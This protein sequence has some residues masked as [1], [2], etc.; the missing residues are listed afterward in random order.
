MMKQ[1]R[2]NKLVIWNI[3]CLFLICIIDYNIITDIYEEKCAMASCLVAILENFIIFILGVYRARSKNTNGVIRGVNIV[4]L[5]ISP[6]IVFY[7]VQYIIGDGIFAVLPKYIIGNLVLYFAI[8]VIFFLAFGKASVAISIYSIVAS[9]WALVDYY[10][11]LFRGRGFVIMDIFSVKTAA[12]V[13]SNYSFGLSVDIGTAL[14]GIITLVFYQIWFQTIEIKPVKIKTILARISGIIIIIGFLYTNMYIWESEALYMW[15]IAGEY[16][17]KG[18][19]YKLAG[20]FQYLNVDKPEGYSSTMVNSVLQKNVTQIAE[21]SFDTK[22][23]QTIP[24][25]IIVIMN[26]S[27]ADFSE[28]N[29]YTASEDVLP[30]IH[31]LNRNIKKG[32][33]YVPSFGGGTSDTEYEVLTGNTKEFMPLGSNAYE[34]YCERLQY[35]LA[36]TLKEQNYT[37]I[38]VH[39]YYAS[40]WNRPQVYANMQFDEFITLENWEEEITNIREYASD[41][42]AYNKIE[43]IFENKYNENLFIF[44]VTMQN[45]GGYEQDSAKGFKASVSLSYSEEYPMAETYLSLEKESD[46]AFKALIEYFESVD[47]PT[48]IVMYGDHWP[49][50]E[51]GFYWALFEKDFNALNWLEVQQEYR[52]PYIIWANYP[53]EYEYEDMSANYFG[54]YILEQAGLELTEYNKALLNMKEKIPIIGTGAICDSNGKWYK[55]DQLSEDYE[56]IIN[57]YKILQYNNV[58]DMKNRVDAVFKLK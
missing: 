32:F 11:T 28:F 52:T 45:H 35:G 33:L 9:F 43:H 55:M 7:F 40:G 6:V 17:N 56:K 51:E 25:N 20:E 48:M 24:K 5:V 22:L 18:F 14:L 46:K 34:L 4:S 2:V 10:V 13:T 26:E 30:Y 1:A 16:V 38:A 49:G 12:E 39:P 37:S 53:L 58:F 8:F 41:S 21:N 3:I 29:N 36:N 31:S 19:L 50:L 15:D 23:N 57:D 44:C 47:E 54:S 42:S 27:L